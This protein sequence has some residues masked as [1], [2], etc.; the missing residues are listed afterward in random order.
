MIAVKK[1]KKQ[2]IIGDGFMSGTSNGG[3]DSHEA[4]C[5]LNISGKTAKITIDFY[6]EDKEPMRGFCCICENNRS[7]HIRLDKIKNINGESVPKDTPY[8]AV[9]KSNRN[10]VVQHSRMDVSQSE[11]TLMTTIAY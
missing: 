8:S 9:L 2:W 3:Y 11:M 10:I 7:N 6:F 5:V 4:L 1:G